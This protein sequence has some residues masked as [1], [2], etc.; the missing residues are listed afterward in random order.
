MKQ[1]FAYKQTFYFFLKK[2]C[3]LDKK[4]VLYIWIKKGE[5]CYEQLRYDYIQIKRKNRP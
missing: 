3:K 2:C 4:I 1:R 5:Q